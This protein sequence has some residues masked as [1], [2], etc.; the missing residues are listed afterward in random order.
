MTPKTLISDLKPVRLMA[1]T[2]VMAL[3]GSAALIA[4]AQPMGGGHRGGPMGG[5][6]A[7]FGGH[8][9][10][11]LLDSVDASA[12]QR[13]RIREIMKGAM[14]D[15]RQQREASRGLREQ[16]M[17]LFTQPTVDARAAEA[18]RRT[19]PPPRLQHALTDW[20]DVL[21]RLGRHREAFELT[22]EALGATSLPTDTPA[23]SRRA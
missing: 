2:L 6:D 12:E 23:P 8:M 11:R 13:T 1:A 10:E 17:T 9:S 14:T 16:A 3:A 21:A 5:P 20:A 22:R 18:L 7:M 15:L 4:Q 19:G